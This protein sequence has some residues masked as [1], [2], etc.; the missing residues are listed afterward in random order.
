LL[1]GDSLVSG[2]GFL[3]E[4]WDIESKKGYPKGCEGKLTARGLGKGGKVL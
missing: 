2:A 3:Q 1:E 4:R